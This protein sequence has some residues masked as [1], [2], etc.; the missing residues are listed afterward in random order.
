[1]TVH[2]PDT[3]IAECLDAGP[4]IAYFSW[5]DMP[6]FPQTH[7]T[8]DGVSAMQSGAVDAG[9]ASHLE[10][11]VAG[12]GVLR[13]WWRSSG[14]EGSD[15]LVFALDGVELE[16]ISGEGGWQQVALTVAG[17]GIH[18]LS[19]SY[20]GGGGSSAAQG[21]G[22][23]D[24]VHWKP[25]TSIKTYHSWASAY[26]IKTDDAEVD[27]SP[28]ADGVHNI[29]K[30]AL[31]LDPTRPARLQTDGTQPGLPRIIPKDGALEFTFIRDDAKKD[32]R[33]T[34]E[35]SG[36]LEHWNP[37]VSG[38]TETPIGGSL[39]RVTAVIPV[40]G[41]ATYCRLNVICWRRPEN[42]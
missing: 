39:V 38:I 5:G 27:A 30:Y 10:A 13:F 34:I 11:E 17:K 3:A 42:R 26:G 15:W 12:D 24:Q 16:R 41:G 33:C 28:A 31:G 14:N 19:W 32:I 25:A 35:T 7:T 29:I 37:V 2:P 6:W 36:D 4:E 40:T 8:W 9:Q 20:L 23:L 1:V 22:W 18:R 21:C